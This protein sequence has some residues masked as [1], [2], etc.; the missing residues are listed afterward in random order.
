M[1]RRTYLGLEIRQHELRAIAVQ[2]GGKNITLAG[3]QTLALSDAVIQPAFKVAN[4]LAPE[5]FVMAL[6]QLLG[7]LAKRE[8]RI[9]VSLP[10]R[11]G[12]LFLLELETPF[13]HRT[14]GI[15]LLRWHLKD[16]L[17]AQP[18]RVALDFQVLE[19]NEAGHKRLL[20]AV[21][22]QDV[23][24]QYES[25]LEQAGYVATMID[26]HSLALYS[27]YRTTVDLGEDFILVGVDDCQ[28]SIMAFVNRILEFHRAKETS[29]EPQKVFQEISRSLVNYRNK[30]PAFNHM[31]VFLHSDWQDQD[32][33]FTAVSSAFDQEVQQ[34]PSPVSK[35]INGHQS[36]FTDAEARGMAAALGVAERMIERRA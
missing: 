18:K 6:K 13:N 34:L 22:D 30:Q 7:P 15:E 26:F 33:L 21:I 11:S 20:A 4:V 27:A 36:A 17:P 31:D 10:D 16:K 24:S 29:R 14:E 25:L 9:A 8:R 19:E 32:N 23:L 1:L 35:L 12:Q 2:R 28:L 5:Q 3:G